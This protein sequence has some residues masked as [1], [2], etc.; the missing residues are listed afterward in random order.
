MLEIPPS[1]VQKNITIPSTP[2][3]AKKPKQTS[4][5]NLVNSAISA[6][7]SS[8]TDIVKSSVTQ[9]ELLNSE[10]LVKSNIAE[11]LGT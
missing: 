1:I 11:K 6:K 7:V 5:V 3:S 10:R 9:A 8:T 2:S 4:S